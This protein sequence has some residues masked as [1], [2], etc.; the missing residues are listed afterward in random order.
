MKGLICISVVFFVFLTISTCALARMTDEEQEVLRGLERVRVGV[1]DL[2]PEMERDGLYRSM[3]Q[4]DM[5]ENLR[6]AGLKVMSE[7]EVLQTP[8]VPNLYLHVD[9]LRFQKGYV[10]RIQLV[11]RERVTLIRKRSEV[12]ATTLR[13]PDQIRITSYLPDVREKAR[14]LVDEFINA[15][16]E[17]NPK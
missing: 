10:Y 3:L 11:M 2:Q 5:E 9:A 4:T 14:D 17:A 7:Q 1:E 15:W 6:M 16:R 12:V 8:N 13:I